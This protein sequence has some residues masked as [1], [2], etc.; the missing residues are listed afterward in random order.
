MGYVTDFH[1]LNYFRIKWFGIHNSKS[2]KQLTYQYLLSYCYE[3]PTFNQAGLKNF[4]KTSTKQNNTTTSK[5]K[6]VQFMALEAMAQMTILPS[7][8]KQ[9]KP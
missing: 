4:T 1:A 6:A 8:P 9:P 5:K 7:V 3:I 2:A